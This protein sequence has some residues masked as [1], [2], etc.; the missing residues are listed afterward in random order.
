MAQQTPLPQPPA[1][2]L[3][4]RGLPEVERIL[5]AD[6]V[7]AAYA[8]ADLQPEM[9]GGLPL[10]DG[11]PVRLAGGRRARRLALIYRGLQPP[12]PVDG[13]RP[14]NVGRTAGTATG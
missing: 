10:A 4:A 12:D 14:H 5:F 2:S 13:G 9:A 6:P 8:I 1:P 11:E 7:W 3:P